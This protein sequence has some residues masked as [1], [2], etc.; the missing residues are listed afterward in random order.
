MGTGRLPTQ[1]LWYLGGPGT[2]RGYGGNASRGDAFWRG[3]VELGSRWPAARLVVFAD[4]GRAGARDHLS[5]SRAL[6]SAGIG[7]SFVDGL[8]RVDLA[9]ATRGPT[10]WRLDFYTDGAL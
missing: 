9:R 3:R 1:S 10:G 2:L 5:L 8:V 7:A 6:F 4:A